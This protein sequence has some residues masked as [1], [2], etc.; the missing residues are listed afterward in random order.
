M[1]A[2]DCAVDDLDATKRSTVRAGYRKD[3]GE[4][5]RWLIW[6]QVWRREVCVNL[7]PEFVAGARHA[8][9]KQG[10]SHEA[11][12]LSDLTPRLRPR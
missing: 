10:P 3:L 5:R 11:S 1:P 6:P 9:A 2:E 12:S 7:D 4:K 8:G